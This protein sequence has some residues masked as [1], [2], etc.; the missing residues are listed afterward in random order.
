M[1]AST[2][3]A[4]YVVPMLTTLFALGAAGCSSEN[5]K[6]G[7]S[8]PLTLGDGAI[9]DADA[10]A[11]DDSYVSG[12]VSASDASGDAATGCPG[13]D[14]GTLNTHVGA[15]KYIQ[16]DRDPNGP[17]DPGTEGFGGNA[18][19]VVG[20][21]LADGS[22]SWNLPATTNANA[23]YIDWNN[24][25]AAPYTLSNHQ[26]LDF[27]SGK[28]PT[29]F[30]GNSSCVGPANNP[31]KDEII[32]AGLANNNEFVDL[33]VLRKASTGDMGYMWLFTKDKPA[34]A[35]E[36]NCS[37]FLK[38][39]IQ[40]GDVLIFGHFR[41]AGAKLLR[42]FVANSGVDET[43]SAQDAIA[44]DYTYPLDGGPAK[45]RW[46]ELET[47]PSDPD[48]VASVAV[49][50]DM[51]DGGAWATAD[52]LAAI[53]NQNLD[54]GNDGKAFEAFTFA[55][56]AIKTST[57]GT[58]GVCGKQ[59][60][61][62]VISK[63]SGNSCTIADVKDLIGPRHVNFGSI[64]AQAH[65]KPNCDG[66]VD[67]Q[68]TIT[69]ASG[70]HS[71]VWKD[72]TTTI[73]TSPTCDAIVGVSL[74]AGTHNISVEVSETGGAGCTTTSP[75]VTVNTAPAPTISCT[76]TGSCPTD[77]T[78]NNLAYS[79]TATGVGTLSYA[80][81]LTNSSGTTGLPVPT[82]ASGGVRVSPVGP[83][84]VYTASAE[85][86]DSRGCKATCA[87]VT[88]TPL[89]P[90][91]VSL[92]IPTGSDR[93]CAASY[94]TDVTDPVTFTASPTGGTGTYS[95][96]W[97]V[98]NC[99]DPADNTTCTA[100]ATICTTDSVSCQIDPTDADTCSYKKLSVTVNDTGNLSSLCGAA[101]SGPRTY[102]KK[103]I[104]D[105]E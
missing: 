29:A 51:T 73:F 63:S 60:W 55:E 47:D 88:A 104:I 98:L 86:T 64:T 8:S 87:Q 95:Y 45:R 7:S 70:A 44:C 9:I 66:T 4:L 19:M 40:T 59:F 11:L 58:G 97:T 2:N 82:G 20:P 43:I 65:V 42:V 16:I 68:V 80:W 96:A 17:T 102:H 41:S 56:A 101:T 84:I 49:N 38:Y 27:F 75:A 26:L 61:A 53:G 48:N 18:N 21:D 91:T 100:D 94:A 31:S 22:G 93:V 67:L 74:S 1:S 81:T 71:C 83:T 54:D 76:L 105:V 15:D 85:V 72:G 103:M 32:F 14:A 37:T 89:D 34:C 13:G 90:I 12:E 62:S 10:P 46:T 99:T 28:D 78:A 50:T 33:S 92:P 79:A 3:K 25:A 5:N 69:P 35:A 30:P 36:G 77:S 39:H 24:L 6:D 52:V 23:S 57:F